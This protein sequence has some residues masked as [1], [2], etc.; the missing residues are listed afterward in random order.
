MTRL[1]SIKEQKLPVNC[2]S[3]VE[4]SVFFD[5]WVNLMVIDP[6]DAPIAPNGS[7][8]FV[9]VV[10]GVV[11]NFVNPPTHPNITLEIG[12]GLGG[13]GG[14]PDL[15]VH[16][17]SMAG[18]P[19]YWAPFN[20]GLAF[21]FIKRFQNWPT[22][23]KVRVQARMCRY[24]GT[25]G[26]APSFWV[27]ELAATIWSLD[28]LGASRAHYLESNTAADLPWTD[29]TH[30]NFLPKHVGSPFPWTSGTDEWLVFATTHLRPQSQ[31]YRPMLLYSRK[32][33]GSST[34][35][36]A[37][38]NWGFHGLLSRG[39]IAQNGAF[40][41]IYHNEY[42]QGGAYKLEVVNNQ[43]WPILYGLNLYYQNEG[44]SAR[45]LRNRFFGVKLTGLPF[46]D[47]YIGDQGSWFVAESTAPPP[48][49]VEREINLGDSRNM[50]CV[51]SSMPVP[52]SES[53]KSFR[54]STIFNDGTKLPERDP[55]ERVYITQLIANNAFPEGSPELKQFLTPCLRG[56]NRWQPIGKFNP[57]LVA[58]Q[59]PY[60]ALRLAQIL[61]P[62]DDAENIQPPEAALVTGP[63]VV[64]VPTREAPAIGGL[65]LLPIT[66]SWVNPIAAERLSVVLE[67]SS[68]Y[69]LSFPRFIAHRR[70]FDAAW[71]A[72]SD[73]DKATLDSFIAGLPTAYFRWTIPGEA[74]ERAFAIV[75][76]TVRFERDEGQRCWHASAVL[77]ELIYTGP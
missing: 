9:L 60:T 47:A 63:D 31:Q 69:R 3:I 21:C 68:G 38:P 35:D 72:L 20:D 41:G 32:I 52:K 43:T 76:P 11:C 1:V 44:L 15:D 16:R 33:N 37:A 19:I 5:G 29:G 54:S 53:G 67:T 51:L 58:S 13:S 6:A 10:T 75:E 25:V 66:P 12:V 56:V 45:V 59:P 61:V 24:G 28:N 18:Q 39:T 26:A 42:W 2:S 65:S 17:Q 70:A 27:N 71:R 62:D 48:P 73:A 40:G 23:D 57:A 8:D 4:G 77:V 64:I 46:Y 34:Y 7:R 22:N 14:G 49:L 50:I 30:Q 55:N 74:T 36:P